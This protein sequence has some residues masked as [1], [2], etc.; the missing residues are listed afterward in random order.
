MPG[1][2]SQVVHGSGETTQ[3]SILFHDCK[4]A[5][6]DPPSGWAFLVHIQFGVH[7]H[8]RQQQLE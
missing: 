7:Q 8:L 2:C 5:E 4:V 6:G 3:P 1:G